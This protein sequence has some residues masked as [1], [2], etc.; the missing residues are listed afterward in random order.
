MVLYDVLKYIFII[1]THLKIYCNWTNEMR[2]LW[3]MN[4]C[5]TITH[6]ISTS[7]YIKILNVALA[8]TTIY[9]NFNY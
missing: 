1:V 6:Y 7:T 4:V 8:F 5:K 2:I 9:V 3:I